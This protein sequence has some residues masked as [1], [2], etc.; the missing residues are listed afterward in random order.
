MGSTRGP[1]GSDGS[2]ERGEASGVAADFAAAVGVGSG[3]AGSL[4]GD[5]ATRW[6]G[7]VTRAWAVV[8]P[9]G[10]PAPPQAPTA[11]PTSAIVVTPAT[12]TARRWRWERLDAR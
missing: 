7:G 5:P 12:R 3:E 4:A 9:G 8:G 11:A 1:D 6:E 10:P 2:S